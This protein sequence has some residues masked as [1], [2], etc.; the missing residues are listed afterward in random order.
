MF[1]YNRFCICPDSSTFSQFALSYILLTV[2]N[3]CEKCTFLLKC[4]HVTGTT[5]LPQH[6]CWIILRHVMI[7]NVIFSLVKSQMSLLCWFRQDTLFTQEMTEKDEGRQTARA[8]ETRWKI[9]KGKRRGDGGRQIPSHHNSSS[10]IGSYL[11]IPW[12]HQLFAALLQR[13]RRR[14]E[15]NRFKKKGMEIRSVSWHIHIHFTMQNGEH[16]LSEA[17]GCWAYSGALRAHIL[18]YTA[19]Q[20]HIRL[21]LTACKHLCYVAK[22]KTSAAKIAL[23][24]FDDI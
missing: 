24:A 22:F 4:A 14:G 17:K 3:R 18:K 11:P 21:F 6:S 12:R 8:Q 16:V 5:T 2:Q 20:K 23:N 1:Y 19:A 7:V 10:H 15:R 13:E 9:I